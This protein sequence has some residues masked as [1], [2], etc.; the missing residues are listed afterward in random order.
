[1]TKNVSRLL[2]NVLRHKPS[3]IGIVLDKN[4]WVLVETLIEQLNKHNYPTTLEELDTI[5]ETNDKKRFAFNED[6]SM[7]RA[8][9]GHS[10]KIDL[11][12]EFKR[13]PMELYHGTVNRFVDSILRVGMSKMKRH[14]VHLSTEIET[15]TQVGSRR[16]D[17][18]ILRVES[19]R[20]YNDG[21]KFQQSENGVWL[22]D[23]VPAKYIRIKTI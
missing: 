15:A 12:L 4:G 14:A 19:G 7:I 3:N 6:K 9:Q 1:M 20:M 23:E 17:A 8:S 16:G 10:V 2:S 22:T 11:Q 13:P 5:V 21:F 18:V